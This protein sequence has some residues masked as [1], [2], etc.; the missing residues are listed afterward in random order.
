VD[1]KVDTGVSE[2]HTAF[3]FGRYNL[4]FRSGRRVK[5][6]KKRTRSNGRKKVAG[7]SRGDAEECVK[8]ILYFSPCFYCSE[9]D[10]F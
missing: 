5:R 1:L 10:G 8:E 6:K 7:R 9:S 4:E 2:E 3:I